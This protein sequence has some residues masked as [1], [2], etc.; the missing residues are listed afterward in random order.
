MKFVKITNIISS[1]LIWLGCIASI[2][3][4]VWSIIYA[5][6]LNNGTVSSGIA[7][8]AEVINVVLIYV[9]SVVLVIIAGILLVPSVLCIVYHVNKSW[10][11]NI[12]I[13]FRILIMKVVLFSLIIFYFVAYCINEVKESLTLPVNIAFIVVAIVTILVWIS[14]FKVY[15]VKKTLEVDEE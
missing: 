4:G 13:L 5:Q 2:F 12:N 9:L 15:Q 10:R 3:G 8:V 11:D 14:T 7:G 6:S 1:I